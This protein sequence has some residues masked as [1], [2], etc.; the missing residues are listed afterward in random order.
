MHRHCAMAFAVSLVLIAALSAWSA[1]PDIKEGEWEMTTTVEGGMMP[2]P[3]TF[4]TKQ[5]L[6][7]ENYLLQTSPEGT[8]SC[9]VTNTSVNPARSTGP[10]VFVRGWALEQL[11]LF[12]LAPIVGAQ[13]A[14]LAF[15]HVEASL[16]ERHALLRLRDR[17]SEPE[18]VLLRELEQVERDALR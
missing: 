7:K 14:L 1:E 8:Q 9:K 12:W 2:Q 15:A 3:M 4:T 16:A 5:C 17:S 18:R 6:T 13:V 11:W 10:A